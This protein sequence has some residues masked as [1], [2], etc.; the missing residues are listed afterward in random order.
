MDLKNDNKIETKYCLKIP[1]AA[2]DPKILNERFQR[3]V[4]FGSKI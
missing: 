3:K 4:Y 1:I 2:V